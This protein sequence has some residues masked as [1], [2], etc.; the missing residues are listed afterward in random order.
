[1]ADEL[2]S[3]VP[4][5]EEGT[6]APETPVA[7]P[8]EA[9][10]IEET[11]GSNETEHPLSIADAFAAAKAEIEGTA[12]LES[13]GEKPAASD[14]PAGTETPAPESNDQKV[15]G[16]TSLD[17]KSLREALEKGDEANLPV[18]A[19][20]VTK[21][22]RERFQQEQTQEKAF[23]DLY[24]ELE[25]EKVEDPDA[26][27]ARLDGDKGEET[28]RFVK[29]YRTAHPDVTLENPE[30]SAPDPARLRAEIDAE[31]VTAVTD[32]AELLARENGVSNFAEL[33]A[34]AGGKV[35][36]LLQTTFNAA[37]EAAAKKAL[38]ALIAQERIA[39]TQEL[40]AKF[41]Q[42]RVTSPRVI[43]G[44]PVDGSPSKPIDPD[45]NPLRGAFEEAKIE[46]EKRQ[47]ATS[48]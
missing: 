27:A 46:L 35:G 41:A 14:E 3:T 37:V 5:P 36:A 13:A 22:M 34:G 31:Y 23:R 1:M 12:P 39:I 10:A 6:P 16:Q 38:P 42:S 7:E 45:E 29:A 20:Q 43:N 24:V 40:T 28:L 8:A 4:A 32:M 47:L 44:Q 15:E 21:L 25:R 30:G 48:R 26:W 9:E 18:E 33:R 17:I 11:P 19:R 2:E